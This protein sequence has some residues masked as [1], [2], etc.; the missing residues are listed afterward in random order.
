[1]A[2]RLLSDHGR[3]PLDELLQLYNGEANVQIKRS[4]LRTFADSKDPRARAKLLEI[5]RGKRSDRDARDSR[6]GSWA[7]RTTSRP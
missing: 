3:L 6:S 1:M 7:T 2:I 4:L 5:A